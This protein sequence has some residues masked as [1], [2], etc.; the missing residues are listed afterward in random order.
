VTV[1]LMSD[2]SRGLNPP[3]RVKSISMASFTADEIEF[4][5]S[6]GNVVWYEFV[7]CVCYIWV[8]GCV[9]TVNG[10]WSN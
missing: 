8:C 4:I 5:K 3:H 7:C 1:V 9:L 10:V 6:R 2:Y